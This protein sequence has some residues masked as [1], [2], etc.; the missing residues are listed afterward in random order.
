ML[1]PEELAFKLLTL[2]WPRYVVVALALANAAPAAYLF[3]RSR[4]VAGATVGPANATTTKRAAPRAALASALASPLLATQQT[5]RKDG[6][7]H[8]PGGAAPAVAKGNSPRPARP[9]AR[10]DCCPAGEAST[11]H[12]TP[13]ATDG[14]DGN[15]GNDGDDGDYGNGTAGAA[16]AAELEAADAAARLFAAVAAEAR[17]SVLDDAVAV[18]VVGCAGVASGVGLALS[19]QATAGTGA[20]VGLL[21]FTLVIKQGSLGWRFF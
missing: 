17:W 6:D 4:A 1:Q 10:V 15:D 14:N 12:G 20:S 13:A 2:F 11:L 8:L 9:H 7:S 3:I 16:A 21:G 18:V 5:S 19:W